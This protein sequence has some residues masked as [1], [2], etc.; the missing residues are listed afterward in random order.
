MSPAGLHTTR[1]GGRLALCACVL[2]G[3][4]SVD[5]L[6]QS[7][8]RNDAKPAPRVVDSDGA[9][10][11]DLPPGLHIAP[12][13]INP[14]AFSP[15][16]AHDLIPPVPYP[17]PVHGDVH[18]WLGEASAAGTG[19]SLG[20]PPGVYL[21][22]VER[23][24]L[25]GEW[26]VVDVR[27]A[28]TREGTAHFFVA[29]P[30][31]SGLLIGLAWPRADARAERAAHEAMAKRLWSDRTSGGARAA[32]A[33]V[34]KGQCLACHTPRLRDG[35]QRD[36]GGFT[37]SRRTDA[38]GFY[39]PADLWRLERPH[40]RYGALPE[41]AFLQSG[42]STDSYALLAAMRAGEPRAREVCASRAV[43]AA[44]FGPP[45][46]FDFLTDPCLSTP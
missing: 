9:T 32:H 6:S 13:T 1:S 39:A 22:R 19:G 31:A 12:L 36:D 35:L 41:H 40:E 29:R 3:A 18:V 10:P 45:P 21:A 8:A 43:A 33:F 37:P 5:P 26:R 34:A 44:T 25:D 17:A 46:D 11:W 15:S 7:S 38:D 24:F 30:S 27:G 20:L 14:A 2:I 28:F 16:H 23:R 42:P 4:C